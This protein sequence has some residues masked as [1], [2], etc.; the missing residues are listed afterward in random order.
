VFK[1][2]VT[3]LQGIIFSPANPDL[4][5]QEVRQAILFHQEAVIH[6]VSLVVHH[7]AAAGL[8]HHIAAD[9]QDR[10]QV[11][12]I[13]QDPALLQGLRQVVDPQVVVLHQGDR[14]KH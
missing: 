3:H 12:P 6:Q 10:Y 9:L 4:V 14:L 1:G 13:L 11:V 7:L 2:E 8:L 5:L